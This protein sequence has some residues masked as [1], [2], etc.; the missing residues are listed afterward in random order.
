MQ[1]SR[2]EFSSLMTSFPDIGERFAVAVSGGADSL[3]LCLLAA[4][5]AKDTGR[6]LVALSVDHGLRTASRQECNG[7]HETLTAK[8]IEHHILTWVGEKPT[9]GIQAAAREARY[10]LMSRWCL[11]NQIEDLMVAHHQDDQAETFLLRLARGSGVDGLGAMK[12]ITQYGE[13]RLLRPLLDIPKSRL[14]ST[15]ETM[16]QDWVEDPSNQNEDFD[17]VKIRKNMALFQDLGLTSERLVQ[18]AHAMQRAGD[19]LQRM[20]RNWLKQYAHLFEEGYCIIE[21]TG[22]D[23]LEDE[24]RLR[25]LARIGMVISGEIYPPRLERL[26]RLSMSLKKGSDATL[27]GCRWIV[28]KDDILVCREVR[29]F[30]VPDNLYQIDYPHSFSGLKLRILGQEG[31]KQLLKE[32]K[33]VD[34]LNIPKPVIY[35]LV[36]FW[37]EEGVLAVPHLGYQRVGSEFEAQLTF[38]AK[39]RLL[40]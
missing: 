38:I 7:L 3:A 31:W 34:D 2:D 16:G 18:T 11:E 23:G 10:Q 1:L 32:R 35:T 36:S 13:I 40:S 39:K 37:D 22:L 33:S 8:G 29:H 6:H 17:R 12:A 28:R 15:L 25:S 21:R 4:I 27:M 19:A 30:D 5:W 14:I 24:I 20:T 26:Q 9:S